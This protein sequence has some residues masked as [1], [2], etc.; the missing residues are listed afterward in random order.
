MGTEREAPLLSTRDAHSVKKRGRGREEPGGKP[1]LRQD[2]TL[3]AAPEQRAPVCD[4]AEESYSGSLEPWLGLLA[5]AGCGG[6]LAPGTGVNAWNQ[7]TWVAVHA[8]SQLRKHRSRTRNFVLGAGT[9]RL[10]GFS[11]L[12]RGEIL[13]VG[14]SFPFQATVRGGSQRVLAT[15]Y[16]RAGPEEGALPAG[17]G[18]VRDRCT[19]LSF[20]EPTSQGDAWEEMGGWIQ[21]SHPETRW[22]PPRGTH[23]HCGGRGTASVVAEQKRCVPFATLSYPTPYHQ[24]LPRKPVSLVSDIS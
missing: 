13:R 22:P 16:Q 9:P 11:S 10:Q 14:S 6:T 4:L 19:W 18:D 7:G 1:R 15:R 3:R 2:P 20:A 17:G 5:S 21:A 23:S 12:Q 24:T 8:A